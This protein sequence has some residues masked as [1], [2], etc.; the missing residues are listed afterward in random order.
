[1]NTTYPGHR[2][3]EKPQCANCKGFLKEG[4]RHQ[5][6]NNCGMAAFVIHGEV[7]DRE[8]RPGTSV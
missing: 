1:M 7:V 2:A 8:P 5:S 6:C 3:G 4:V